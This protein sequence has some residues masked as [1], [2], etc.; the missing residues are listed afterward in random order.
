MPFLSF[1]ACSL[2]Q[3]IDVIILFHQAIVGGDDSGSDIVPS[4]V[5]VYCVLGA[6]S[7]FPRL[8]APKPW[9]HTYFLINPVDRPE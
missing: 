1:F 8:L 5:R 6:T 2:S 3:L 9:H 4:N 7:V